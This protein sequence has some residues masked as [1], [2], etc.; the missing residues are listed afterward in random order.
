MKITAYHLQ[1]T[2]S[3]FGR[4]LIALI[5]IVAG[6]NKIINFSD[7]AAYITSRGLAYPSV[8]AFLAII[9]EL[10]GGLMVF[11]GWK[12]RVGACMLFIFTIPVTFI[13]HSFWSVEPTVTTNLT[14]N[15]IRNFSIMGAT[16]YLIAYGAGNFSFDGRRHKMHPQ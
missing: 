3:L 11:L 5:F 4:V 7:A 1:D 14:Q 12:A 15:L 16:L 10:G 9:F 2:I 8:I 6:F 13:F